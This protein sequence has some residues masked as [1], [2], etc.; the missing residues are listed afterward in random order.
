MQAE[1]SAWPADTQIP[2]RPPQVLSILERLKSVPFSQASST[3]PG[4]FIRQD[5][6]RILSESVTKH[7]GACGWRLD[8]DQLVPRDA[9]P[10][11]PAQP[12]P[13]SP[14]LHNVRVRPSQLPAAVSMG[15]QGRGDVDR[16]PETPPTGVSRG[17]QQSNAVYNDDDDDGSEG[18]N[19]WRDS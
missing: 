3:W 13:P 9:P 6:K 12:S 2:L 17:G 7:L 15:D 11:R 16:H 5:A 8:G 14:P 4:R 19:P 18:G 10:P 1:P